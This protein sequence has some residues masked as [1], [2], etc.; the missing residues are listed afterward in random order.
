MCN[1]KFWGQLCA[2]VLTE[3]ARARIKGRVVS[4]AFLLVGLR[5]HKSG[6]WLLWMPGFCECLAFSCSRDLRHQWTVFWEE[7]EGVCIAERVLILV[8][9]S[10]TAL[11][12]EDKSS[13]FSRRR[14]SHFL[15]CFFVAHSCCACM[16]LC[17]HL[18]VLWCSGLWAHWVPLLA[19]PRAAAQP[20][21]LLW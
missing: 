10:V 9:H 15:L 16:A 18:P 20:V 14:R 8:L 6:A 5:K 2:G 1:L 19:R 7:K 13:N 17:G 4:S 11:L 21:L 12:Y 3:T